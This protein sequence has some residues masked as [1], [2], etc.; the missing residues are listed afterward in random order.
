MHLKLMLTVAALAGLPVLAHATVY[1][2]V[3]VDDTN[4]ETRGVRVELRDRTAI[5][6]DCERQCRA[7]VEVPLKVNGKRMTFSVDLGRG[8][9]S[10]FTGEVREDGTLVLRGEGRLWNAQILRPENEAASLDAPPP[11][12]GQPIVVPSLAGMD[13]YV[14]KR[15]TRL[16][17]VVHK[18]NA[19]AA[20]LA[21]FYSN[22]VYREGAEATEGMAI[23]FRPGNPP[24]VTVHD[25]ERYC[26]HIETVPVRVRGYRI[27]FTLEEEM[28]GLPGR[29]RRYNGEFRADGTL[30]VWGEGHRAA[31]QVLRP[32]ARE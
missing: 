22:I 1:S 18:E 3:R 16:I 5:V 11:A 10:R 28:G 17:G 23:D 12:P 14:E 21:G 26:A 9:G 32:Q 29:G 25:C 4:G 31:A 20:R 13:F 15:D 24:V 8:A 30:K 27:A 19:G 7:P 2:N 6:T